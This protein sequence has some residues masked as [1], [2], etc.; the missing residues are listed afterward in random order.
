MEN[1]RSPKK[2]FKL[3]SIIVIV[4]LVAF[5]G[6]FFVY[7]NFFSPQA[8]AL[9][10]LDHI[11]YLVQNPDPKLVT[12]YKIIPKQLKD[13]QAI[14]LCGGYTN[15]QNII[16]AK[17]CTKNSLYGIKKL[18]QDNNLPGTQSFILKLYPRI[19]NASFGDII[20]TRLSYS[21]AIKYDP[22]KLFLKFGNAG[23]GYAGSAVK[24]E[25]AMQIIKLYYFITSLD[26]F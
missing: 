3:L 11:I 26:K 22:K 19:R 7:E 24:Q 25:A 20:I 14:I 9:G 8:Q 4:L 2:S 16:D 21:Q 1:P 12:K 15:T 6:G 13:E 18:I 10:K 5:F 23:Q 17:N